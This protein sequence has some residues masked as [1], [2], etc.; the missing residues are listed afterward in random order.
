M[1]KI[2]EILNFAFKD[3]TGT[4][5]FVSFGSIPNFQS[6]AINQ[7]CEIDVKGGKWKLTARGI[8]HA[9]SGH[10][11][12][13][14]EDKRGQIAITK[15]NFELLP[16]ILSSPDLY[17]KSNKNRN[18]SRSGAVFVKYYHEKAYCV[19]MAKEGKDLVFATMYIKKNK[20]D[21]RSTSA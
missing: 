3:E 15:P 1:S 14:L 7:Y 13:I 18:G 20:A 5:S 21:V 10:G 9:F 19:V 4:D 8:R 11:D 2:S 12:K 17:I 16:E 6:R